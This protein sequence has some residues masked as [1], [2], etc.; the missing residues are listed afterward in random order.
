MSAAMTDWEPGR[1]NAPGTEVV[2]SNVDLLP[3]LESGVD[4]A[5][6][7][8]SCRELLTQRAMHM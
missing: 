2:P 7:R 4:D 6:D 5:V 1:G 8:M 3:S